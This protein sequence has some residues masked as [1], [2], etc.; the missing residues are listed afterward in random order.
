MANVTASEIEAYVA[1]VINQDAS[2]V[3]EVA[4][5]AAQAAV[6]ISGLTM[7]PSSDGKAFMGALG[8]YRQQ[9][10]TAYLGFVLEQ[11]AQQYAGIDASIAFSEIAQIIEGN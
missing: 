9:T 6:Q 4:V 3:A 1:D 11:Y 5:V 7:P 8:S 2:S 10:V